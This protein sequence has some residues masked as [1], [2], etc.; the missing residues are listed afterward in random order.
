VKKKVAGSA[1]VGTALVL[2]LFFLTVPMLV[3]GGT[4]LFFAS[5]GSSGC[6]TTGSQVP[7]TQPGISAQGK[8]TIPATFLMW[9]K[10]VGLQ[11]NIPWTI[12]AGIG[13]E[14]SDNGQSTLPGVRSG[15]N[16]F[17][18]AGPMQIGVGGASTD[19]WATV[20]TSED[21]IEP[22]SVYDPADA[23]AGA[24]KYLNLHGFQ[25]DPSAA[26]FA[27]NHAT[28]YVTAVEN[29]ANQYASGGFLVSQNSP[30]TSSGQSD[31]GCTGSILDALNTPNVA[32]ATAIQFADEQIGKPYVFGAT[33]PDAYDCSGLVMMAYRAAGINI[34]RTSSDQ[35][36]FGAPVAASA[37]SPGDLVFFA[38]ADGTQAEP[39]HVGLV[40]GKN[41]MIEAYA[42]GFPVRISTFG[43][44]TSAPGEQTGQVVGFTRP[45][46][47]PGLK[48][49][50]SELAPAK[51][52]AAASSPASSRPGSPDHPSKG[53][54]P[55][56]LAS[57]PPNPK[58]LTSTRP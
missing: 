56:T 17:G 44:K 52:S 10:K 5:G 22:P 13:T 19:T 28:W 12:L 38:G 18:A 32:V 14:E 54:T 34:P 1:G 25:Q 11:Y 46:K 21:G 42:T 8:Q 15:T 33:G 49:P 24:A 6:T 7:A 2:L 58:P 31:T 57:T 27:Y 9:Y 48:I 45:W 47:A 41:T 26:I 29:F 53:G 51:P 40:I 23:I 50:Q 36:H 37:V 4:S 16:A 30:D 43:L 20:A 35:Y 39:G 3:I 55:T